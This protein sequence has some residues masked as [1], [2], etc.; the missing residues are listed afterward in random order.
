MAAPTDRKDEITNSIGMK[1][2][3][4][5]A[6]KFLM[7]TFHS[8]PWE[9]Y[10]MGGN[11]FQWCADRY[12][13]YQDG[14]IKDPKG[15]ETGQRRVLRGG[16]WDVLTGNCRSSYR[17]KYAP[18]FCDF[19]LGFRVVL[20]P[21]ERPTPPPADPQ[22]AAGTVPDLSKMTV[23]ARDD[24]TNPNGGWPGEKIPGVESQR[25]AGRFSLRGAAWSKR[26]Y[27]MNGP[28]FTEGVVEMVGRVLGPPSDGWGI[29]IF[30]NN[31]NNRGVQIMLNSEAQV[32]IG[33]WVYD[34]NPSRGPKAASF[35]SPAVKPGEE[36]NTLLLA[37]KGRTITVY[38]NGTAVGNPVTVEGD[39]TPGAL[40]MQTQGRDKGV[41]IE[42]RRFTVWAFPAASAP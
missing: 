41:Q 33:P 8:N 37:V 13:K 36:W 18:E 11:V 9:L 24:F 28:I 38:V 29:A 10:D 17:Y 3:L 12:G 2:K 4:I 40:V 22:P 1:L 34:G 14:S 27:G 30:N 42:I 5:K 7:G 21:A 20:R 15:A 31:N 39:F 19:G 23:I 32:C 26:W 16:S 35:K 6:G 25:L